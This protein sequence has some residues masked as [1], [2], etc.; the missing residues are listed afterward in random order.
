MCIGIIRNNSLVSGRDRAEAW[1]LATDRVMLY[2]TWRPSALTTRPYGQVT[3]YFSSPT[4]EKWFL[5][6]TRV[7]PTNG[8]SIGSAIFAQ[9]IHAPDTHTYRHRHTNTQTTLNA[10][11]VAIGCISCT[12]CRRCSLKLFYLSNYCYLVTT[13]AV[14]IQYL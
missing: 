1:T 9:L 10:T 4:S 8:I 14:T 12:V 7:S 5:G 13:C 2:C 3:R 6:P 11:S